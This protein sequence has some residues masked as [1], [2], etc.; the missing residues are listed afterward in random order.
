MI[1]ISLELCTPFIN[2]LSQGK[3]DVE[4]GEY[5]RY[6]GSDWKL[7]KLVGIEGVGCH[8]GKQAI[9]LR[10]LKV[11]A[12]TPLSRLSEPQKPTLITHYFAAWVMYLGT[13]NAIYYGERL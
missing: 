2:I 5:E 12:T 4:L 11:W 6:A 7:P 1:C 8:V 13:I 3:L 10:G 9:Q